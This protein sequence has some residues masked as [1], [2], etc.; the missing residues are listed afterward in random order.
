[1][2]YWILL[3][4]LP[5]LLTAGIAGL[6]GAPWV[7]T[8]RGLIEGLQSELPVKPGMR[9]YDLGCGDGRVLFSLN[10]SFPNAFFTGH[11]I[12]LLPYLV[13][14]LRAVQHKNL[15]IQYKDVSRTDYSDADILFLF[16]MSDSS[17]RLL[18]K[19]APTLKPEAL[20]VVEGWQPTEATPIQIIHPEKQMPIFVYRAKQWK[21]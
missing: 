18:D 17:K 19:L 10:A 7:P 6:K 11:E 9:I 1:M 14:K 15:T 13:A 16:W 8:K 5:F 20:I 4:S 12:S 21:E 2:I 3:F